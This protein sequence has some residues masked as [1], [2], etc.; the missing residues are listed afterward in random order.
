M[1]S[2]NV[3]CLIWSTDIAKSTNNFHRFNGRLRQNY[4]HSSG[5]SSWLIVI[6]DDSGNCAKIS[7]T[8]RVNSHC[9]RAQKTHPSKCPASKTLLGEESAWRVKDSDDTPGA[10]R[11]Q[12]RQLMLIRSWFLRSPRRNFC[13][14]RELSQS[15]TIDW[16]SLGIQQPRYCI[17]DFTSCRLIPKE[18]WST[19]IS[20]CWRLCLLL[21]HYLICVSDE[22]FTPLMKRN[23]LSN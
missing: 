3:E 17:V 7:I 20:Q 6:S 2:Y 13:A 21:I 11:I 8:K 14:T 23:L 18:W 16:L 9:Q 4:L 12:R 19:Q 15:G 10:N 1:I 5:R 22:T